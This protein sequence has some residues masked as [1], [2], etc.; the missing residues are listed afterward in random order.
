M[1]RTK[2]QNT[3]ETSDESA[4]AGQRILLI[5][6]A[7]RSGTTIIHRA[8]CTAENCNPHLSESW[9]IRDIVTLYKNRVARFESMGA[10]QFGSIINFRELIRINVQYYIRLVSARYDDPE[11]LILKHP[12]LSRYFV[13]LAGLFPGMQFLAV[14]RD[15]RDVIASMKEVQ[16]QNARDGYEGPFSVFQN[17]QQLCFYYHL[18]Y[19]RLL[20]VDNADP[21]RMR[22][23]RYEDAM[24]EPQ[25]M[26]ADVGAMCGLRYEPEKIASFDESRTASGTFDKK[27]RKADPLRRGFWSDLYTKDITEERIGR[28]KSILT[29]DEIKEVEKLLAMIGNRFG[30]W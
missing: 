8:L 21:N 14:V 16:A 2:Q 24:R 5:G 4:A 9:L 15:P 7:M 17:L 3:E 26:I 18:H 27:N 12:E 25:T 1:A 6:G 20:A 19:E 10:D 23:L 28:Y 11:V 30:Y 22:F 29:D 13:E